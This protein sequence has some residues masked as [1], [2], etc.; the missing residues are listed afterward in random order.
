IREVSRG[1]VD[2][3]GLRPGEP[4]YRPE[5]PHL[6][7]RQDLARSGLYAR[8]F[9]GYLRWLADSI[10][11]LPGHVRDQAAELR[12]RVPASHARTAN[13]VAQLMVGMACF[14]EYARSVE[15]LTETEAE[16]WSERAWSALLD[17]AARQEGHHE[18]ARP[19]QRFLELLMSAIGSGR[20]HVA[21]RDG[22][23][24]EP[25]EAWGW[26]QRV[27]GV[28]EHVDSRWEPQGMRVG[29]LDGVDL[30]LDRTAAYRAAGE[31][32]TENGIA[33]TPETL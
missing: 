32:D 28:G 33:V 22:L 19:E 17:A 10:G 5:H 7:Q 27:V 11:R 4:S 9:A 13:N 23:V 21:D 20:A 16:K 31:M 6:G 29:W 12:N 2:G 14:L 26:R 18:R 3:L 1:D 8:A 25:G 15:A 30:Y 24:P